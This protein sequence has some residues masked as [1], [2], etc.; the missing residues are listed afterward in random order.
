M[1][2]IKSA[3][4]IKIM[5]EGGAKLA[6]VKEALAASVAPG[7]RA[8]EIEDL[9]VKL[10]KQ[11]GAEPSFKK[12]PDYYW[13]TCINLNEGLVHGIPTSDVLFRDS[14][15]VKIDVGIYYK[16]FHTDTSI[17]VGIN[18][19]AKK[20]EF[21]N[22]GKNALAKAIKAARLGNRIYD[23]SGAIEETIEAAGFTTIKALVGHGV[24]REL[25]EDP[26]IPCFL[27]GSIKDSPEIKPGMTLAIEVMYAAGSD[28][29]ERLK[30]GWTIA[31]RDGKISALFED[32]VAITDTGTKVL[33][34]A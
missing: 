19:D 25:H 6:R 21:L 18:I 11:E 9:A 10:I 22:A 4:E 26:Q 24:G 31:M 3:E 12:V 8:S 28:K 29:V 1:I 33:T 32:T 2:Q 34:A 23:I 7:V 20:R 14:D 17:S 27:P 15:L 13:A 16:G 30:D 5:A